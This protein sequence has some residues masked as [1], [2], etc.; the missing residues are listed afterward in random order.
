MVKKMI[1]LLIVSFTLVPISHAADIPVNGA[2]GIDSG[3]CGAI[4][5][6]CKTITQAVTNAGSGINVVKI[7]GGEY[8]EYIRI[9]YSVDEL[10]LK[11]GWSSNFTTQNCNPNSTIIR[12]SSSNVSP[13]VV[14]AGA[15]QNIT[16]NVSCLT[17]K[18]TGDTNRTGVDL[19]AIGG[20]L[21]FNIN[22]S[23][24]DGFAG[25]GI[26]LYSDASG[27]ADILI[28]RSILK[29]AYQPAANPWS[30]GGI[31]ISADGASTQKITVENCLFFNNEARTG[32]AIYLYAGG[33]GTVTELSLTNVTIKDNRSIV[34]GGSG[35]AVASADTSQATLNLANSI[36]WGNT[37][38]GVARDIYIIQLSSSTSTVNAHH[39]IVG[40]IDNA[41]DNP[42][43]YNDNGHNMNIDPQLDG[44]Y[45]LNPGSPAIDAAQC[46]L[47]GFPYI[48]VAP[49]DDIDGDSRPGY[50]ELTGCDIGADEYVAE[51]ICFPVK[52][53]NGKTAI[54]CM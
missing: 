44:T 35:I 54:I 16:V 31:T 18:G 9:D 15:F 4:S 30:G 21:E 12:S 51:P 32:A 26:S 49:Y 7:A 24:V 27:S 34:A 10:S 33:T 46:G 22:Q 20:T 6:P 38:Q 45:H 48:R 23:I 47:Q 25:Q 40:E 17:F 52:S 14:S 43:T 3:S 53:Q 42:G 2:T 5:A 28:Q 11:G 13:I 50:G 41:P 37:D 36:V 19:N 1:L 39:S 8:S 29:N